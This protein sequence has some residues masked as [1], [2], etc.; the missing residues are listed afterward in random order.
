[1]TIITIQLIF[2][3]VFT[4][5]TLCMLN[6]QWNTIQNDTT[7]KIIFLNFS[8]VI[9]MKQKKFLEKRDVSEVVNE[10]FGGPF[11][12]HWFLPIKAGGYRP[13]FYNLKNKREY[14]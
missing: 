4:I 9:D 11:G 14:N 6:D 2:S 5:F 13:F 10:T 1:M 3:L 7:C 8:L 12:L